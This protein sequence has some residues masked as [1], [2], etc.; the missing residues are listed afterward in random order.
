M[1]NNSQAGLIKTII[2]IIIAVAILK[3]FFDI[4]LSDIW[5]FIVSIWNNFLAKPFE[6]LAEIWVKYIWGPFMDSVDSVK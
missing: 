1:K 4:D 6:Y 3:Y 2:L 5:G